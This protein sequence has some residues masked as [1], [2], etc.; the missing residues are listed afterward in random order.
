MVDLGEKTRTS[1]GGELEKQ[2]EGYCIH[3]GVHT[4]YE[5]PGFMQECFDNGDIF[6]GILRDHGK[7]CIISC[8]LQPEKST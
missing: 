2:A 4:E 3:I 8:S 5:Y 7:E 1:L 6:C